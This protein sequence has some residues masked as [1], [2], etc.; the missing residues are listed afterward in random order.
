[1]SLYKTRIIKS[2]T[3]KIIDL[4]S[5]DGETC[6]DETPHGSRKKSTLQKEWEE[7]INKIYEEEIPLRERRAFELGY[8]KGKRETEERYQQQLKRKIDELASIVKELSMLRH[9]LIKQTEADIVDL[10]L[11]MAEKIIHH[12][13][14][15]QRETICHTLKAAINTTLER[16]NLIIHLHPEDYR[17]LM[18]IKNEFFSQFD[19]L[20]NPVFKEDI[21]VGRGGALIVTKSGEID[22]RIE[23]QLQAMKNTLQSLKE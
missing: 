4:Q 2:H 16:D 14:E 5:K 21:S 11:T 23:Q 17:F 3:V 6:T 12:E 1:M 13:I 18:E 7:R 9:N 22:A 8:E 20:R 15:T 10:S 19:G